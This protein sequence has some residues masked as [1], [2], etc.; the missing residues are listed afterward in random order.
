MK[1]NDVEDMVFRLNLTYNEFHYIVDTIYSAELKSFSLPYGIYE[2]REINNTLQS[3]LPENRK[4]D[5][6]AKDIIMK[7]VLRNDTNKN[8]LLE[9]ITNIVFFIKC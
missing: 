1:H 9:F 6:I 2:V 8:E 5:I 7:T 3:I 4:I